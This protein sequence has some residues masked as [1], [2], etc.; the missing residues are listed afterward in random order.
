MLIP[1]LL[2]SN[3]FEDYLRETGPKR[4]HVRRFERLPPG[5]LGV[6]GKKSEKNKAKNPIP[7][8]LGVRGKKSTTARNLFNNRSNKN[9][10][11]YILRE[12]S[13]LK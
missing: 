6:R 2:Q 10:A 3:S 7:G 12:F 11:R 4:A 8:F 9:I 5:F 13:K 1:R